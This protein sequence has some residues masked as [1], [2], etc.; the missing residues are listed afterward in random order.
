[1]R[2][3]LIKFV[4]FHFTLLTWFMTVMGILIRHLCIPRATLLDRNI[5]FWVWFAVSSRILTGDVRDVGSISG[6]RSPEGRHGNPLQY[7][8]LK[9]FFLWTEKPG[10][11]WSIMLQRVRHDWSDHAFAFAFPFC[12]I[13]WGFVKVWNFIQFRSYKLACLSCRLGRKT[14]TSGTQWTLLFT[15]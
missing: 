7:S 8:C 13:L 9:K 14:W 4:S 12:T 2:I 6:L 15:A 5:H 3:I 10:G 11:L 1:M